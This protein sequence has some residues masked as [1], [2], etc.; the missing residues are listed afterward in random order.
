[1]GLDYLGRPGWEDMWMTMAFLIS[2]KSLDPNT[3]HGCVVT[4]KDNSL[5]SLGY[6]SPP[7]K[8]KDDQ[9]PLT[10]PIKY[11]YFEHAESNAIINAA[12]IGVSLR[13]SIFYITG[14]PCVDCF[15][16]ILNVGASQI[17]YGPIESHMISEEDK[18]VI[19][20]L[21]NM[22]E[23]DMRSHLR[24]EKIAPVD[25]SSIDSI[26]RILEDTVRYIKNKTND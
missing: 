9:I 2:R 21:K 10:R 13:D 11:K 19:K 24:F 8:C 14:P 22:R 1:M 23:I 25:D 18:K 4:D 6:N 17:I 20:N 3:K 15:R 5:L 26:I 12:R 16:K 7:R